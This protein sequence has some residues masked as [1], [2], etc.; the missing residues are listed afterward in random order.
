VKPFASPESAAQSRLTTHGQ[1]L[2]TVLSG[3][4]LG[5]TLHEKLLWN[6]HVD[7]VTKKANNTLA[8]LRRNITSCPVDVKAQCYKTLVRPNM[9]YLHLHGTSSQ[10]HLTITYAMG[11][12]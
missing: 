4:Y 12:C 3:R 8:C 5:A 6:E 10:S 9:E 11:G 7:N 2:A 1:K